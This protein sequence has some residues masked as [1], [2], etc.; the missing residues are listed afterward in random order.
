MH[1]GNTKLLEFLKIPPFL[2]ISL[3]SGTIKRQIAKFDLIIVFFGIDY[4]EKKLQKTKISHLILS[5]N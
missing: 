5:G 2:A 4:N 3:S 1:I